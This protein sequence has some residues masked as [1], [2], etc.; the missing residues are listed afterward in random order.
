[1]AV[2]C[3][4]PVQRSRCQCVPLLDVD[5]QFHIAHFLGRL[6]RLGGNFPRGFFLPACYR[7][8]HC[9]INGD[10]FLVFHESSLW[11]DQDQNPSPIRPWSL[12]AG[13][14]IFPEKIMQVIDMEGH[15]QI[16]LFKSMVL[17]VKS[18]I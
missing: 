4:Q 13:F 10:Y 5:I 17:E 12:I 18:H 8:F 1:M 11:P 7:F 9:H 16:A 3:P 14:L 15:A 2:V 6:L